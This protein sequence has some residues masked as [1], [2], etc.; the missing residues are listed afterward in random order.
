MNITTI[1]PAYNHHHN[2][3]IEQIAILQSSHTRVHHRLVGL[4]HRVPAL[5]QAYLCS[6]RAFRGLGLAELWDPA[7]LIPRAVQ[8]AGGQLVSLDGCMDGESW[9]FIARVS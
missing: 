2:Q 8:V 6:G 4:T 1:E 3:Q 5:F 7:R 9:W